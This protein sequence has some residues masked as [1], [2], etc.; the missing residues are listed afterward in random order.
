MNVISIGTDRKIFEQDSA[1][2]ARMAEYGKLFTELH[3]IVFSVGKNSYQKLQIA[4]NVWVYPTCSTNRWRYPFDA[5]KIIKEK[6]KDKKIDVITTQ[7][8][9]ETGLAG[10]MGKR[11]LHTKLHVQIHTDFMSKYFTRSSRLNYIRIIIARW[12]LPKADAIRAVSDRIKDSLQAIDSKLPDRTIVL[13]I[14]T[15]TSVFKDATVVTDLHKE[16]PQF[17]FIILMASRLT[18]EKN[19]GF[20][21]T[22]LR[23][24]ILKNK[25]VGMVIVGDGPEKKYLQGIVLRDHLD[26]NVV[27]EPWQ[28]NLASYYRTADVFLSTSLYEGYG[29]TLV[30]A[31]A[32]GCP[33]VTTDVG[34]AS[35]IIEPGITGY[36]CDISNKEAFVEALVSLIEQPGRAS[37]MKQA[38]DKLAQEK[39]SEPKEA[40]LKKYKAMLENIAVPV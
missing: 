1:V 26:R 8:P 4:P 13:P 9:F 10:W 31:A 27:F 38:A 11:I 17:S 37:S 35:Q 30:E 2:R 3:I 6:F 5:R 32:S 40:Y 36:V 21:L 25:D 22:V 20:A 12:L 15:D 33:I 34:I 28:Q 24:I 14:H 39:V 7:D 16:Y 23:E 29:L 18:S 19:I